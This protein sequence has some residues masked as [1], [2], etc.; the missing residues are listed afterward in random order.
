LIHGTAS[1]RWA[2]TPGVKSGLHDA[3]PVVIEGQ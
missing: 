1:I 2:S 3:S